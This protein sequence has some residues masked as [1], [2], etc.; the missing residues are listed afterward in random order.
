MVG[1]LLAFFFK[2]GCPK[3]KEG[4]THVSLEKKAIL[5]LGHLFGS[6]SVP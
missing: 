1:V 5:D 4:H 3:K 2:L 6:R